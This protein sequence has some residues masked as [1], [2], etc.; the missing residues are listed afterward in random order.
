MSGKHRAAT[1]DGIV[2][3]RRHH[4]W[5]SKGIGH[6]GRAKDDVARNMQNADPGSAS[7][8]V[9]ILLGEKTR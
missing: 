5:S 4:E 2:E 9:P 7:V 1:E 8:G 3:M 6:G